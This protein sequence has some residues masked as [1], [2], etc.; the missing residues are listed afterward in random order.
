MVVGGVEGGESGYND[1]EGWSERRECLIERIRVR[2][3]EIEWREEGRKP[4]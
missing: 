4:R 2:K 3:R 1:R